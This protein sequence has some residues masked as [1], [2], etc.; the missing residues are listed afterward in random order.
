MV[1]AV[2]GVKNSGK[3]TLMEKLIAAL[4]A[5]GL[6]VAAIKHDGHDFVPDAPGTDSWRYGQAGACGYAVFS[7]QRFQIVREAA[8]DERELLAAFPDA[9]VVLLEGF[10]H[11]PWPKIEVVRAGN[12]VGPVCD[13]ATLLAVATDLP[14]TVEG[15]PVVGLEDIEKLTDLILTLGR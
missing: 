1:V 5:R 2:S 15:A 6:R 3:T 9:E 8:V 11:S 4:T 10:K 12:S 14:L 7:S 13:P